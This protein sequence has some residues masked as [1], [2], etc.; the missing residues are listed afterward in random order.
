MDKFVQ[1]VSCLEETEVVGIMYG[2]V[3]MARKEECTE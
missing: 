2:E 1:A 3:S